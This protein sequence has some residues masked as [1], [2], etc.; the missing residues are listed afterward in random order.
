MAAWVRSVEEAR[1]VL[2]HHDHSLCNAS[3]I[4]FPNRSHPAGTSDLDSTYTPSNASTVMSDRSSLSPTIATTITLN[5][6]SSVDPHPYLPSCDSDRSISSSDPSQSFITTS[7]MSPAALSAIVNFHLL[8]GDHDDE[9]SSISSS[10][11]AQS[12]TTYFT[13]S[14]VASYASVNSTLLERENADRISLDD[15]STDVS[16]FRPAFLHPRDDSVHDSSQED[17]SPSTISFQSMITFH[18]DAS[19]SC[20]DVH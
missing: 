13:M 17:D 14:L 5:T 15:T 3:Q 7:T 12:S 20:W 19:S 1:Q 9:D 2:L 6:M 11:S 16:L 10:T 4:F 18:T 8:E